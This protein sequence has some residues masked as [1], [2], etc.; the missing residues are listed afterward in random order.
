LPGEPVE[1]GPAAGDVLAV[2]GVA[3]D[4]VLN[5]RAAPGA[6]QPILAGIPPLYDDLVAQGETRDLPRSFWIAVD[7]EGTE[8]WVNLR[9]IGYLGR[10]TDITV[11]IVDGISATTMLELGLS[12]AEAQGHDRAN[13]VVT[14][15][16]S[17]G[18]ITVDVVGLEDDSVRGVRFHVLGR[19][20]GSNFAIDQVEATPIC[21]RGVDGDGICV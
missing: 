9:Y 5:L 8:G 14:S 19:R 10:T 2:V 7:Y 15:A 4:D 12:V 17:G 20:A 11:E 6:T 18:E 1:F 16:P 13:A 21:S 3:H